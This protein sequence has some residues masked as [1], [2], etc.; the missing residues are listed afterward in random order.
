MPGRDGRVRLIS[1]QYHT[2][3]GWFLLKLLIQDLE[4]RPSDYHDSRVKGRSGELWLRGL[5]RQARA[6]AAR[7]VRMY[8]QSYIH[9]CATIHA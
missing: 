4:T 6:G 3:V 9:V 1:Y 8:M 2:L 5:P 7:N